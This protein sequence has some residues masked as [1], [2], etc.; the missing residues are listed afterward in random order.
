MQVRAIANNNYK[1]RTEK[2]LSLTKGQLVYLSNRAD[3]HWYV[4]RVQGATSDRVGL[5]PAAYLDIIGEYFIIKEC[6][7]FF[8]KTKAL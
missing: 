2:E 8:Q 4:G 7:L 1:A 5:I 6:I 3:Y